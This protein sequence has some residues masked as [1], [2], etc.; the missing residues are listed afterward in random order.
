MPDP[1]TLAQVGRAIKA[2]LRRRWPGVRWQVR[3]TRWTTTTVDRATANV[4]WPEQEPTRA[5]VTFAADGWLLPNSHRLPCP[6]GVTC[7]PGVKF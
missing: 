6:V 1:L 3:M 5:E 2:E 7:W 4:Y